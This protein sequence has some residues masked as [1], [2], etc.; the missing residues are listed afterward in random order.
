M[1]TTIT[2]TTEQISPATAEQYLKTNIGHQ[3]NVTMPHVLHLSQQMKNNQWQMNGE[4][5]IF[6][7]CGA[8]IDGQHRMHAVIKSGKT[9]PF[10]VVRGVETE[11]FH[12]INRGKT[13]STANIFAIAGHQNSTTLAS[14]CAG[15]L[16]YRRA[17]KT[18]ES[19][20]ELQSKK[21]GSLNSYIRASTS[22]MLN[23]YEKNITEYESAVDAAQLVRTKGKTKMITSSV[24]STV[25]AIAMIDAKHSPAEVLYFWESFATG[26]TN[27]GMG[28]SASDPIFVFRERCLSNLGSSSKLSQSSVMMLAIKA[29]NAYVTNKP[30]KILR[31][32]E[33]EPCPTVL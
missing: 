31:I 32:N 15:V 1:K 20:A 19:L 28:L 25:S 24:V 14:A 2:T 17:I 27:E 9:I 4:P 3:R 13:R 26:Q 29:W 33:G 10:L 18:K 12:S 5:I 23:E 21:G 6:D 8:M 7:R 22:D 16:N 30:V 11:S